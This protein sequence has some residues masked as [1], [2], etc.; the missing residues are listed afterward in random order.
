MRSD[1]LEKLG[2][3]TPTTTE[4]MREVLQAFKTQ[5]PNGNGKADE[6]PVT[7]N[8]SDYLLPYF[9]N[10]F[11]YCPQAS[12]TYPSTL[13][14]NDGQVQL[15]AS[16]DGWREGLRYVA[17]LYEDGLIDPGAFTDNRDAT[18]AKGDNADAIIVG[19]G[20]VQHPWLIA[21]PN[22]KDGRDKAYDPVPPLTGPGGVQY[23]SY[24]LPSVPGATFVVT[25][26]ASEEA[27]IKA[28]EIMDYIVSEKGHI[29]GEF[30]KE[31]IGWEPAKE[32]EVALDQ[33]LEPSFRLIPADP[34]ELAEAGAWGAIAGTYSPEEF[35]NAQ[36][37]S[38]DIYAA[39]G[40][41]RRL[42]EATKLYEG[43][44][45]E[46]QIYPYWNVWFDPE[47]SSELATLQTNIEDFVNQSSGE[48]V[49]GEQDINSD[50]DW[51]A[52]L[53][54]LDELGLQRYLE[55]HQEAYEA[56]Q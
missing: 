37:A 30:G 24:N 36:V 50:A 22:Q 20:T 2:L 43:H 18:L 40:G 44:E 13:A 23:A 9:M 49:T 10:A 4:E 42:Y 51:D 8:T 26:E 41:E 5:D 25:S 29:L 54:H 31:G 32:G 39:D 47:V 15:Q 48:F 19:A 28:M 1:W 21:T 16:Q 56:S 27:Q 3:E 35:R 38:T 34:D 33:N 45:P 53:Q 11:I 46:D 7:G 12:D 14:L 55:I 17:S 52:Y 6:I